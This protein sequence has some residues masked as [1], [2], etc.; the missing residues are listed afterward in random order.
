M[1]SDG[2]ANVVDLPS[3]EER[4]ASAAADVERKRIAE[5]ILAD[6]DGMRA[7]V[8]RWLAMTDAAN[9]NEIQA[10]HI[11]EAT[12]RVMQRYLAPGAKPQIVPTG[13]TDLDEL[14]SLDPGSLFV[15]GARSGRGKSSLAFQFAINVSLRADAAASLY[16]SSEM[17]KEQLALRGACLLA[18]V[19]SKRV[20]RCTISDDESGRILDAG[21]IIKRSLA[22]LVDQSGLDVLRIKRIARNEVRRIEQECGRPVRVI[23]V[24]YL[25]RVRAGK[26]AEQGSNREQA[27]TAVARELKELA[28]ELNV[29]VVAPAQLNKDGDNRQGGRPTSADMRESSGIENEADTILLI[30]NPHYEERQRNPNYDMS[31]QESCELI[32]AKGRS[33]GNGTVNVWFTPMFTRFGSMTFEDKQAIWAKQEAA[34]RQMAAPRSSRG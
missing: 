9:S 20:R 23:I 26:A 3:P 25:Q 11:Q 1:T 18:G 27:V 30:H 7:E 19:D 22:W 16:F 10:E 29:C 6:A 31:K 34:L 33:D 2:F 32:L 14:V 8:K 15:V 28:M 5:L 4:Q 13:F 12:W 24:D 17:P 21:K